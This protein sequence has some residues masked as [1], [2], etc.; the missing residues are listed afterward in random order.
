MVLRGPRSRSD[1]AHPSSGV[2]CTRR[3]DRLEPIHAPLRTRLA[4]D[5]SRSAKSCRQ[6]RSR[7]RYLKTAELLPVLLH[8]WIAHRRVER[9]KPEWGRGR[10]QRPDGPACP[11]H[12]PL[13]LRRNRSRVLDPRPL[14]RVLRRRRTNRAH[15]RHV[16]VCVPIAPSSQLRPPSLY[17]LG[18]VSHGQ[19]GSRRKGRA[20]RLDPE[21]VAINIRLRSG[22]THDNDIWHT[23][24]RGLV[25]HI[26]HSKTLELYVCR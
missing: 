1:W 6:Q 19:V 9:R 18:G 10:D 20:L 17:S 16:R 11:N 12:E 26:A 15:T 2:R 5:R 7:T 21:T 3:I 24:I 8:N 14:V 4:T 23:L 25:L 22:V 13:D